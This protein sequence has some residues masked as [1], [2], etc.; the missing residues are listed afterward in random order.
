METDAGM[1]VAMPCSWCACE[2]TL[3]ADCRVYADAG[4]PATPCAFCKCKGKAGCS[5]LHERPATLSLSPAEKIVVLEGQVVELEG[6]VALVCEEKHELERRLH[7]V[8]EEYRNRLGVL[9]E[10]IWIMG[11]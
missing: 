7:K 6:A 11:N 5:A 3:G 10:V 1:D 2:G 8:A 4:K 9:E